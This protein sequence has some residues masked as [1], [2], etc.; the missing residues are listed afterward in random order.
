MFKKEMN[1]MNNVKKVFG[2]KHC[3]IQKYFIDAEDAQEY[4]EECCKKF[5]DHD[6][7]T[8]IQHNLAYDRY[9]VVVEKRRGA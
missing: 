3:I 6:Y 8:W 7:D 4:F 5:D 9:Q 1:W 2:L